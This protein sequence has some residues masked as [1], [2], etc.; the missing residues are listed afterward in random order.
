MKFTKILN[1]FFLNIGF[2]IVQLKNLIFFPK[3]FYDLLKFRK[4]KG[5][6]DYIFPILGEHKS[7]SGA[8]KN[9][10]YFYPDMLVASFIFDNKP[11]KHC[12]I[13]SRID[14][15]VS[16]V[17]VFREIEVFDIR[18]I[19]LE[20]RNILIKQLD[21]LKLNHQYINYTDSISCLSTIEHFG[22]GRYGDNLDPYGH[23]KGF[24]N[25]IKMVKPGGLIYL[26][27]PISSKTKIYFNAHRQFE[28]KSVLEWSDQCVLK[29]FDYVSDDGKLNLNVD[30]R[31]QIFANLQYGCGIYSFIKI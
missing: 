29:R 1:R 30:L 5:E 24:N 4:L 11:K 7:N 22:L 27:V 21:L 26:S 17:A 19:D 25:I 18:K 20:F 12:D 13:G 2:N 14:G 8:T 16:S 28:P 9:I 23:I 15:F 3:F 31:S 10:E 6:I